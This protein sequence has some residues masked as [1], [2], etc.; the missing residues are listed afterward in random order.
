M[1]KMLGISPQTMSALNRH[2]HDVLELLNIGDDVQLEIAD[3]LYADKAN[4]LKT[5]FVDLCGKMYFAEAHNQDLQN[6]HTVDIINTWCSTKTH[7]KIDKIVDALDPAD[8]LVLLNSVYFKGKW[9]KPF[10]EKATVMRPFR[11][12]S[13]AAPQVPMMCATLGLAYLGDQ[14]FQAVSI[15]YAGRKQQM[16]VFLPA[17][18]TNFAAFVGQFTRANWDDWLSRFSPME[19]DLELPKF[20]VEF[21]TILNGPLQAMGMKDAFSRAA[22]FQDMFAAGNGSINRVVQKTYMDVNEKGTEAAAVTANFS[23]GLSLSTTPPPIT[24]HVDRP[25]VIALIDNRSGEIL[26]LGSIVDP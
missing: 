15:P 24:F 1:S 20:K 12:L 6:P 19:V 21:S 25:F 7:G 17:K 23:K 13:G 16:Y 22:D 3:A 26:F 18:R 11:D 14:N 4:P 8:K 10:R 2:N 9:A 5:S